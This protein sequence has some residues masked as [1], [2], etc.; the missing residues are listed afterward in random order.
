MKSERRWVLWLR[1]LLLPGMGMAEDADVSIYSVVTQAL[2]EVQEQQTCRLTAARSDIADNARPATRGGTD[3]PHACAGENCQTKLGAGR[4]G[5]IMRGHLCAKIYQH[6]FRE[7]GDF[8]MAE[9]P[10]VKLVIPTIC[11]APNAAAGGHFLA[12]CTADK[13]NPFYAAHLCL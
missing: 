13:G 4:G 11:R 6:I 9:Y 8:E 3:R 12:G 7:N 10:G 5:R 1:C 2:Q